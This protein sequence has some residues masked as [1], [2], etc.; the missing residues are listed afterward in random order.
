MEVSG[1]KVF[2]CTPCANALAW[3]ISIHH[4]KGIGGSGSS[5]TCFHAY[6]NKL[7]ACCCLASASVR[8]GLVGSVPGESGRS[9]VA[10]L[11][12]LHPK[13]V[14]CLSL[15][16][17]ASNSTEQMAMLCTHGL[18]LGCGPSWG[19]SYQHQSG[20]EGVLPDMPFL[21]PHLF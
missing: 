10:A 12:V 4:L 3:L 13:L 17:N 11:G 21:L 14:A 6:S 1:F 9:C 20:H 16:E 2:T 15:A 8:S 19:C 7:L 5:K 18:T